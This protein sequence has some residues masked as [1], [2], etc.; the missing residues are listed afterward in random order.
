MTNASNSA[1]PLVFD[2]VQTAFLLAGAAP[3]SGSIVLPF[4]D[5]GGAGPASDTGITAI[6]QGIVW[7]IVRQDEFPNV[8]LRPPQKRI[9]LH[10]VELRIPLNHGGLAAIAGLILADGADPGVVANNGSA[11]RRDL[12][13]KK[14]LVGTNHVERTAVLLFILYDCFLRTDILHLDAISALKALAQLERLRKLGAR[15]EIE[16]SHARLNLSQHM[17]DAVALRP[18]RG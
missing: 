3:S 5:R 8:V 12:A 18:K 15:F 2:D 4:A 13:I 9:D 17:D 6:V 7:H 16:D 1:S 11:Q 10:E 14:T